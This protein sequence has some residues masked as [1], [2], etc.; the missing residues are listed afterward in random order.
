MDLREIFCE[1]ERWIELAQDRV[2]LQN[3]LLAVLNL[4]VLLP[5]SQRISKMHLREIYCVDGR[6]KEPAFT[7]VS[8]S[9]YSWTLKMEAICCPETSVDTQRT[10]PRY[11]PLDSTLH[12]HRYKNLKSYIVS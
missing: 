3:C 4:H 10:T 12:N 1:D 11:I 2:Q 8:C 6:W 9:A 7:L 5:K